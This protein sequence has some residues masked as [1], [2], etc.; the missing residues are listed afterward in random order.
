M[1]KRKS[2]FPTF[3]IFFIL[4]IFIFLLSRLGFLNGLTGFLER[5]TV[6]LQRVIFGA[7]HSDKWGE[8]AKLKDENSKLAS[9]IVKQSELKRENQALRDQFQTSNPAPRI[10]LPAK[11]IGNNDGSLTIDKGR[12]DTLKK[13]D[14][15]VI[16]DNLI[17]KVEKISE[18]LAT[19]SL[20][21]SNIIFTAKT[22]KTGSVGILKGQSNG[23]ILDNVLLNDHLEKDD[24]VITKGD[25]DLYG[26]GFPPDLVVG[27]IVSVNKKASNLFQSA[28]VRS[29]IDFS[30]LETVFIITK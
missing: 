29:L 9:Q 1:Q 17:G 22:A 27:K 2:F 23:M 25:E 5:A 18:H 4:S 28:E 20:L 12:A 30:K 21:T 19:V 26:S 24:L 3:L 10:L 13:G 7:T 8:S 11:I 6:P 15:V 16:K 14:V